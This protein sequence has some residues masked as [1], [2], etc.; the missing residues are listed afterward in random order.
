M[1][2]KFQ[3]LVHSPP[4]SC[5]GLA[6]I[7]PP[8]WTSPRPPLTGKF[9]RKRSTGLL[10]ARVPNDDFRGAGS[11]A[12][13]SEALEL[14]FSFFRDYFP[15]TPC[16][17]GGSLRNP[18]FTINEAFEFLQVDRRTY[19][20]IKSGRLAVITLPSGRHRI[21][22]EEFR[23]TLPGP[24]KSQV[25]GRRTKIKKEKKSATFWDTEFHFD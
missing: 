2:Q 12:S 10:L 1:P 13:R 19:R 3:P 8:Y 9:S 20:W 15:M 22:P 4:R 25:A 7:G 6:T 16:V 24:S 18:L 14:N 5:G 21:R 17:K 11:V 23:S